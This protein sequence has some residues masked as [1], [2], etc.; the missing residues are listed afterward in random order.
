VAPGCGRRGRMDVSVAEN[1]PWSV[2]D[3]VG[4]EHDKVASCGA[5]TNLKGTSNVPEGSEDHEKSPVASPFRP[6]GWALRL[7]A[8][9]QLT[10]PAGQR[11]H[12]CVDRLWQRTK[13]PFWS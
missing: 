1:G 2:V 8:P 3:G 6:S 13:V 7:P 11:H 10:F 5:G 12:R 9:P 4:T